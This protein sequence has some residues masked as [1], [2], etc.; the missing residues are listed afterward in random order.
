MSCIALIE[1]IQKQQKCIKTI[2]KK[3]KGEF[4]SQAKNFSF[5]FEIAYISYILLSL[6]FSPF[7]IQLAHL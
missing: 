2:E 6:P 1:D 7:V 4:W 5:A 3:I